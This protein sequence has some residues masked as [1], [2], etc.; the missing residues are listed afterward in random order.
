MAYSNPSDPLV[1]PAGLDTGA[2]KIRINPPGP[3]R[4]MPL[5]IN[6]SPKIR[7]DREGRK[8]G[9]FEAA[10]ADKLGKGPPV[11]A[12]GPE[13]R[14]VPVK[15]QNLRFCHLPNLVGSHEGHGMLRLALR[16]A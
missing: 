10:A 4:F 13:G 11:H 6:L 7:Q 2:E 9:R 16:A 12:A 3:G 15:A 5:S 14:Q 8:P 1:S